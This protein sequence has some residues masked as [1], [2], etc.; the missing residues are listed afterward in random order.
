MKSDVD[1]PSAAT[2]SR[3]RPPSSSYNN[4][5]LTSMV[6]RPARYIPQMNTKNRAQGVALLQRI[7]KQ[8]D[9]EIVIV[10]KKDTDAQ[11]SAPLTSS[12]PL[13]SS[14]LPPSQSTTNKPNR[15][16]SASL[17]SIRSNHAHIAATKHTASPSPSPLSSPPAPT[18]PH[19]RTFDA[20]MADT[21]APMSTTTSSSPPPAPPAPA[22]TKNIYLKRKQQ[23]YK[24]GDVGEG[25]AGGPTGADG[26]NGTGNSNG[27][28][29]SKKQRMI[30]FRSNNNTE[31][32][33][34]VSAPILLRRRY[35]EQQAQ[36]QRE[37]RH[38][39][40]QC[41][42]AQAKLQQQAIE[43]VKRERKA[44]ARGGSG[45]LGGLFRQALAQ[46]M[47]Q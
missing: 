17:N 31:E 39:D 1:S 12:D 36:A 18:S 38:D 40:I 25:K 23:E 28:H 4:S 11:S 9:I 22:A 29:D 45:G 5:D 27:V 34:S 20:S 26:D 30:K 44:N 21:D 46:T 43:Q 15:L 37:R 10:P 32:L 41:D 6:E 3:N 19:R 42:V 2:R 8:Y 7:A 16:F 24:L 13:P 35:E 47:Q 14:S 33:S